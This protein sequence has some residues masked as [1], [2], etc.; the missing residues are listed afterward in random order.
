M[1][2]DQEAALVGQGDCQSHW[3][4]EHKR[5]TQDFLHGLDSVAAQR[6]YT[7]DFTLG[8]GDDFAMVDTSTGD[9]SITLPRARNGIVKEV[10]KVSSAYTLTVLPSGSDTVMGVMGVTTSLGGSALRFKAFGTDWRLI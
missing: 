6:T 3:H 7:G 9:V 8:V 4:S 5:A 2:P 10:L 1:T